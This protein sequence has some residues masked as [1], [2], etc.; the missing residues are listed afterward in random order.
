MV[1]FFMRVIVRRRQ[2]YL[3]PS[4]GDNGR[5][6]TSTLWVLRGKK[7]VYLCVYLYD[8]GNYLSVNV[9]RLGEEWFQRV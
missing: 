7:M 3:S 9:R 4:C 6:R 8:W 2:L 5:R 1:I